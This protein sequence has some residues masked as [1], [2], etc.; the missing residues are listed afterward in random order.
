MCCNKE[1]FSG[2]VDVWMPCEEN[3]TKDKCTIATFNESEYLPVNGYNFSRLENDGHGS[4]QFIRPNTVHDPRTEGYA[5]I[6]EDDMTNKLKLV[7][8]NVEGRCFMMDWCD[9]TY[10]F[11]EYKMSDTQHQTKPT[12]LESI[13]TTH[14]DLRH[15]Q[16]KLCMKMCY[17]ERGMKRSLGKSTDVSNEYEYEYEYY[18]YEYDEEEE[19]G[20]KRILRTPNK[21]PDMKKK[22][23]ANPCMND[24]MQKQFMNEKLEEINK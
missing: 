10:V 8:K 21:R 3:E 5:T 17:K 1:E 15:D 6:Y 4:L 22:V 13:E 7:M 16:G 9:N 20:G 14:D 2:C 12:T 24:C 23:W 18:Y 11:R 19:K